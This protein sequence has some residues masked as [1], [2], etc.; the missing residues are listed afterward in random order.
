M[1]RMRSRKAQPLAV[2]ARRV[3]AL[4]AELCIGNA[5]TLHAML[6]EALASAD[7][8]ILDA[9]D[10]RSADSA[11]LQLLYAFVRD[12][13]AR[14]K[15]VSWQMSETILRRDAGLLGLDKSLG[16]NDTH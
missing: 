14:G 2:E 7:E 5:N 9:T 10:V 13:K 11:G 6:C 4:G 16:L 3:V 1:A 15:A 12:S 8:I